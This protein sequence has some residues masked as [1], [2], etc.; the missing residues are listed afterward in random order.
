MMR[1]AL[2]LLAGFA[3]APVRGGQVITAGA[4]GSGCGAHSDLAACG[5][6]LP[7]SASRDHSLLQVT[8]AS[9]RSSANTLEEVAAKN[10][11]QDR[12]EEEED[13]EYEA[14]QADQ[15]SIAVLEREID[16]LGARVATLI[17]LNGDENDHS[18]PMGEKDGNEEED[19]DGKDDKEFAASQK[20]EGE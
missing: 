13:D 4:S 9:V 10:G 5:A 14:N 17:Q 18:L 16:L 8:R 2:V 1:F 6:A 15:K 19:A 12:V 11:H 7:A 3:A 20:E